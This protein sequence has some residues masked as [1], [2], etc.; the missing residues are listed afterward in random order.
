MTRIDKHN[1]QN[2]RKQKK[3][4]DKSMKKIIMTYPYRFMGTHSIAKNPQVSSAGL[5]LY[6]YGYGFCRYGSGLDLTNPCH[7]HV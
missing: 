3:K 2:K 6:L 4:Q 7:T 5:Y 1:T